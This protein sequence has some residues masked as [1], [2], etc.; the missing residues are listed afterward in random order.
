[1]KYVFERIEKQTHFYEVEAD[2]LDE[3]LNKLEYEKCKELDYK[4]FDY[5]PNDTTYPYLWGYY[6]D[7]EKKQY[8]K[9]N[10]HPKFHDDENGIY[11]EV[12]D[13]EPPF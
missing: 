7:E 6:Y 8:V 12:E 2:N 9:C 5:L 3:A 13:I 10:K 4:E 11:V 1:M